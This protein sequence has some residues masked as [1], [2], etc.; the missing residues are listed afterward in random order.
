MTAFD[1]KKAQT[2]SVA[3][4]TAAEKAVPGAVA[5]LQKA[6]AELNPTEPNSWLQG[7]SDAA[8]RNLLGIDNGRLTS[9]VRAVVDRTATEAHVPEAYN[10][11]MLRGGGLLGA[12]LGTSE[13]VD[14][15]AHITSALVEALAG[16]MGSQEALIRADPTLRKTKALQGAFGQ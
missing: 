12:V 15:T 1:R 16:A 14:M 6:V 9:Q 3:M 8:T 13:T 7:A 4:N 10:A 2:L 11:A 5:V